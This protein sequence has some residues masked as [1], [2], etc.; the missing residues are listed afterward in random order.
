M[1]T[2]E[3]EKTKPK[4]DFPEGGKFDADGFWIMP[5]GDFYDP[6]G[7]HFSKDGKD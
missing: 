2:E 4:V 1:S 6:D 7:V 3:G 5:E